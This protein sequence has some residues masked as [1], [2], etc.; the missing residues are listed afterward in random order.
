MP[1][2]RQWHDPP[3]DAKPRG[4]P[5]RRPL[6]DG[7][8]TEANKRESS[9][10]CPFRRKNRPPGAEGWPHSA[11]SIPCM[12]DEIPK[13]QR[14]ASPPSHLSKPRSSQ[15]I[16]PFFLSLL[17]KITLNR[18]VPRTDAFLCN[19]LCLLNRFSSKKNYK[20]HT[21]CTSN[22]L[23]YSITFSY[24]H[25]YLPVWVWDLIRKV[26]LPALWNNLVKINIIASA[27]T[28]T[29]T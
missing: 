2:L 6:S 22:F 3:C 14:H 18:K 19:E 7:A 20:C 4:D 5:W 16:F 8:S 11:Q 10:V 21:D 29:G 1:S 13:S 9:A 27:C 23:N 17:T 25:E 15:R 28:P 12:H 26:V 24:L